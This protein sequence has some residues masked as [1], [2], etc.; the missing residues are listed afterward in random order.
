LVKF[1]ATHVELSRYLQQNDRLDLKVKY[2]L[3]H[4]F[5][6]KVIKF[7]NQLGNMDSS[8]QSDKLSVPTDN[9]Y[10]GFIDF[11]LSKKLLLGYH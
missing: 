9:G 7:E 10:V 5:Y 6:V 2:S 3:P 1:Q 11:V 8:V 4:V